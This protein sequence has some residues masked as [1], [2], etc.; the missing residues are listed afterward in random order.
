M[1]APSLMRRSQT[2]K[3]AEDKNNNNKTNNFK[4]FF[5]LLLPV[6]VNV[7]YFPQMG[8]K[9][10]KHKVGSRKNKGRG[11]VLAVLS[12]SLCKFLT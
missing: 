8:Q 4:K 5:L 11:Q 3:H 7:S 12:H 2:Y 9:V 1:W 6:I 10:A